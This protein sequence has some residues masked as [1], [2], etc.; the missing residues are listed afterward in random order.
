MEQY[1]RKNSLEIHG[2]PEEAY[3]STEEAVLKL[4]EV[5]EVPVALQDIEISHKLKTKSGKAVIVKFISHKVF[6][7]LTPTLAPRTRQAPVPVRSFLMKT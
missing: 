1:T 7:Y 3:T 6:N 2:I 4:A 5:L